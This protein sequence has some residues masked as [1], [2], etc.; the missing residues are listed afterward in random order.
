MP[1]LT[2]LDDAMLR[3]GRMVPA[4]NRLGGGTIA[5]TG[6]S[7]PWRIVGTEAVVYQLRQATGRVVALRCLLADTHDPAISDRY[8]ALAND[9]AGKRLRNVEGSPIVGGISFLADG[10]ALPGKDFRS[11]AQPVI[12]MD[13][14]MGP[15]LTAAMDRA[16]RGGDQ[17]YLLAL[18]EAWRTAMGVLRAAGFAHGNLTGDNAMVRPREGIALVDY[19][20][21]HWPGAP[22]SSIPEPPPA[23]RHPR[24]QVGSPERRDHFASF[25]IYASLRVLAAWPALRTEHGDP[26]SEPGGALL[27]SAK[28]LANPDGSTLFGKIRVIDDAAVQALVS[29]LRETCQSRADD[30][31]SFIEALSAATGVA[32]T[33]PAVRPFGNPDPRDR[34]QRLTRLNSLLLAGNDDEA[35]TYW[36]ASGLSDDPEAAREVGPRIAALQRDRR[37]PA[38]TVH[39]PAADPARSAEIPKSYESWTRPPQPVAAVETDAVA[40]RPK[41]RSESIE[42]LRLALAD[43]DVAAVARM[44]HGVREDADASVYAAQV[45]EVTSKLL[46][47]AIA[48]AI[49]R[50]DG[51]GIVAAVR[52]AEAQGVAVGAPARKAAREASTRIRA[53]V[54]FERALLADDRGTLAAMA[55]SGVL[56]EMEEFSQ[57]TNRQVIRALATPHLERA[58][59]TDD[60]LAIV[61]AYSDDVFSGDN[62]LPPA[63]G[64][65]VRTA[66]DRIAWLAMVRSAMRARD[67]VALQGAMDRIPEGA[68]ARL[69]AVERKR[70]ERMLSQDVALDDLDVA[71]AGRDDAA[72]VDALNR[73]ESVGAILPADLDWSAIRGVI[74]RLSLVA[75]IRRAALANPPE[76]VRLARLLPQAREEAGGETPY[77]GTDLDFVE[78]ESQVRRGAHL[79][80]LRDAIQ[81]NDDRAIVAAADPDPYGVLVLL[82]AMHRQ[83]V[84]RAMEALRGDDA[85]KRPSKKPNARP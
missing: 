20:T 18:A 28:D 51:E 50:G 79:A 69:S 19:D 6:S 57:E 1:T 77:L 21:A 40:A 48:G 5:L 10:L 37:N 83:R 70:I 58:L 52:E 36:R 55:L 16:C 75:S 4:V 73:V 25:L 27:F 38:P 39:E 56:D 54:A 64:E 11:A 31:P 45:N 42:R 32:R 26:A 76:H 22:D 84:D 8:R 71:I 33:M 9:T 14:V 59:A 44:W 46:G 35:R 67:R 47:A 15:T 61:N 41:R 7:Q 24:G 66:H 53:R 80:R 23:F 85:F 62:G 72:I 60:D 30:A 17:P 34:Q 78:L 82:S 12:A 74:D 2:L 65:R 68:V 63:M 13:W 43:G 49:E 29:V 3:A 81:R